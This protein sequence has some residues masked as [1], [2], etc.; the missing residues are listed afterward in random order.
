MNKELQ[1]ILG[2]FQRTILRKFEIEELPVKLQNWYLMTYKEFIKELEK[3]KIKLSL[4]QEEEWESH[5]SEKSGQAQT[6]KS[7]IDSINK[8]IDSMVFALYGLTSEDVS[9]I[10]A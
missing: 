2:K 4:S 10:E 9:I 3:K 1:E 8:E 5:F 7:K 6:I